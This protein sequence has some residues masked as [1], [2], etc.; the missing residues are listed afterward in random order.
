MGSISNLCR[1]IWVY[2][3]TIVFISTGPN[4]IAKFQFSLI[5]IFS[6]LFIAEVVMFFCLERG[7]ITLYASRFLL[8]LSIALWTGAAISLLNYL[9]GVVGFSQGNIFPL[10]PASVVE[11]FFSWPAFFAGNITWMISEVMWTHYRD[12]T[13]LEKIVRLMKE[14]EARHETIS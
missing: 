3:A 6:V 7:K 14:K 1:H 5:L 12:E 13:D 9:S 2:A 4:G 11:A 8:V 10:V